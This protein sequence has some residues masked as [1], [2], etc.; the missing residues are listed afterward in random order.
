MTRS[1]LIP[2][3][4]MYIF[5]LEKIF[6]SSANSI[7]VKFISS[8]SYVIDIQGRSDGGDISVYNYPPKK[9]Q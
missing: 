1:I 7:N 4:K 3:I 2:L 9:N 6:V 8:I 5:I